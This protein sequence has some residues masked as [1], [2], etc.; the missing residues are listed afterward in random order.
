MSEKMLVLAYVCLLNVPQLRDTE[1][2]A[3]LPKDDLDPSCWELGT[4]RDL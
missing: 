4:L 2:N 3:A 1:I